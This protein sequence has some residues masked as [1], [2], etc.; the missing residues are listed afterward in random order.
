MQSTVRSRLSWTLPAL[1]T[2]VLAPSLNA[3][4]PERYSVPGHEVAIYN[5]A[6]EVRV[7]P[8][9]GPDV[10]AEVTRGGA[11]AAKLKVLRSEID[12][13][14]SL[15]FV[16]PADKISYSKLSHGSSTQLR[17][18]EDG[19]FSDNHDEERRNEGRRITISSGGGGLD[20]YA[21]L[22]VT[23]PMGKQVSLYLAVG[24]VSVTNVE[25]NLSIDA[26][27][28]PVTT[29]NTRGELNID[30]GSGSVQVTQSRGELSIDTGSGQVTGTS[31]RS[32]DLSIETGS[33]DIQMTGLIAPQVKLNTGSGAVTADVSGE[34]WN[35]SV[36]TG[37]GDITLKVPPTIGAEVDIET[38][39]GEIE[40][41]FEV[42]VTRHARDHMTGRIGDGRG[43]ID[44]ETGS[45]GIKLVKGS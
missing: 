7:E 8:G 22:R 33:G 40:T 36:E 25:G 19:T 21:D 24:K 26:A 11:D 23:V 17:V 44:I 12:G 30:V 45:G 32:S 3:Q 1:M 5:L 41:D 43:K 18:R 14:Q 37:S 13:T 35:L 4:Q 28:A 10:R 15:R 38:S 16:Y 2:A 31:I 27:S 29:S 9:P 6:G 20:A 42:A 39:S 34:L